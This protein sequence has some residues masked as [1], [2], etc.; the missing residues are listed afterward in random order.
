MSGYL[1]ALAL[2]AAAAA[3]W[4][5]IVNATGGNTGEPL[6]EQEARELAAA[7][8]LRAFREWF[9]VRPSAD[10]L[11]LAAERDELA[12]KLA[13]TA[14]DSTRLRQVNATLRGL[15]DKPDSWGMQRAVVS[16]RTLERLCG[17]EAGGGAVHGTA[18]STGKAGD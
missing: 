6:G 16:R 9:G 18:E 14:A 12:A 3:Q 4:R 8:N 11:A 10:E 1:R 13:E 2:K 5:V 17:D 7:L 15:F